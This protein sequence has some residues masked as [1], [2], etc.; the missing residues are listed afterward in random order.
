MKI[1]CK[2]L[3]NGFAIPMVGKGTWMTDIAGKPRPTLNDEKRIE[4]IKEAI[5][6]G[7]SYIDTAERY[8]NGYGEILIGKAIKGLN[9]EKLFLASKVSS[10]HLR[11]DSVISSAKSSL[12]RLQTSYL[13]LYLIHQFNPD[14]PLQ[15]TMR[16]MDYLIEKKMIKYIGVCNFTAEQLQEAQSHTKNKIVA[17]QLR[18]NFLHRELE[19][20][21]II[22]YCQKHDIVVIACRPFQLESLSLK[23]KAQLEE[24]ASK[25]TKTPAQIAA[26]W[27]M[28]QTNI[29]VLS[30]LK[31]ISQIEKI[32]EASQIK[33]D[34]KDA[35]LFIIKNN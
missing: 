30:K 27:L 4:E 7:I 19:Q 28:L 32:V 10:D 33:M 31:T 9:R 11:Y 13:D 17:N 15:E 24:M 14:L 20:T 12:K 18:Y 23:I 21:G 25:Y 34:G 35:A 5:A 29:V 26:A 8:T 1:Q 2:T 3:K 16:A 22:E 6:A